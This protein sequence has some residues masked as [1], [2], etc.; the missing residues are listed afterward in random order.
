MIPLTK[1]YKNNNFI[2]DIFLY[3]EELNEC[4]NNNE[5]WKKY[6]IKSYND[7]KEMYLKNPSNKDILLKDFEKIN[8]FVLKNNNKSA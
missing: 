5:N 1:Y 4:N 7:K 6:F 8:N 2:N 3:K